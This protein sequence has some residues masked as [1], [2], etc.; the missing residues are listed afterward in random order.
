MKVKM[1]AKNR[2]FQRN[3]KGTAT[4]SFEAAA[5]VEA[6]VRLGKKTVV[7]WKKTSGTVRGVPTGGPYTLE[8]RTPDGRIHRSTGLLVGDLWVLAGQSN[9]DGCGKL[10]GL[11][12][13]SRMV[14]CYYYNEKWALAKDPLCTL[15]DSIDPVHWSCPEEEL[16]AAR[17]QERIH[18]DVGG[19]LGVRFGKAL[20]KATGIPIGL[21]MCSHGG[22][23]IEQWDPKRK[24]E[25]GGS[26][27]GSMI[28][29]IEACGGRVTGVAWYQ[30][31]SNANADTSAFYKA[32]M[33]NFI[34]T[35]RRDLKAPKLPFLQVQLSRFFGDP[36][37]FP[38]DYWNRIQQIQLEISQEIKGVG[39]AAAIDCGL[40][41][42]IHIDSTS[43]RLMGTRLAELALVL[44]YRKKAP[45][46][47]VPKRIVVSPRDRRTVRI[48]Y[49]NVRKR[50][51]PASEVRGFWVE[52]AE[53]ARI[54]IASARANGNEVI[55]TLEQP[56]QGGA[57]LWYGRGCNPATNLHDACFA[58]P[59]FGPVK[60]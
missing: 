36:S 56:L 1:P 27:Y 41:D 13:P 58:G 34:Q 18:R 33:K 7:A 6:R 37:G 10:V 54:P 35:V 8:V 26:L 52:S 57:R 38:P 5:P 21:I 60:L 3:T 20:F 55:L 49:K 11:E 43:Q 14:H 46:G 39:L 32:N 44:A 45:L 23:S 2:V 12:P 19:G 28:R 50:L 51:F 42:M 22:T 48:L 47:L 16:P 25:G 9:M 4:I 59:V 53:G 24:R 30:G 31:E 15:L 40:S 17:E 29:R